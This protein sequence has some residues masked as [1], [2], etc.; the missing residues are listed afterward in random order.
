MAKKLKRET[1]TTPRFVTI[2]IDLLDLRLLVACVK[3]HDKELTHEPVLHT[4]SSE[5][6]RN[7]N[8]VL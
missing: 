5:V 3:R 7:N 1:F 8:V 4:I 2:E 6:W